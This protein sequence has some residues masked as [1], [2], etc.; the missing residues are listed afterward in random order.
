MF[1]VL[2]LLRDLLIVQGA[3]SIICKIKK[4]FTIFCKSEVPTENKFII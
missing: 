3:E 4:Y 2:I 1:N